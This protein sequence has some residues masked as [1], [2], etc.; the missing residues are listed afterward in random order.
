MVYHFNSHFTLI[1][2]WLSVSEKEFDLDSGWVIRFDELDLA[3]D[4]ESFALFETD[5]PIGTVF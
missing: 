5:L 1:L 4:V 3:P 2:N